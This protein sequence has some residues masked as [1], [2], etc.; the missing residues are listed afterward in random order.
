MLPKKFKYD[1]CIIGGAGHIGFPLGLAFA[2][3]KKKVL[4][5]DKNTK[6]LDLIKKKKVPFLE[7]GAENLLKKYYKYLVCSSNDNCITQ[8][9]VIIVCIGTPISKKLIPEKKKFLQ[10]FN[11]IK[12]LISNNQLLIIRSSVYPGVCDEVK[13]ILGN[14]D[15][16][17]YCPERIVQGLSLIELPRLTQLVSGFNNFSIQK[18]T[19]LFKL[20]CKN[21]IIV[22]IIEAELIKLFSNAYRYINF[23]ISNQFYMMCENVG[24]NFNSV[25]GKMMKGYNRNSDIPKPGFTAGPCLLKDTMQLSDFFKHKFP[26]GKAA[27]NINESLPIFLIKNFEKKNKIKNKTVGVLGLAFKAETDDT[28]DS[29]SLKLIDYLKKKKIK[30]LVSDEYVKSSNL[31]SVDELLK[32]SD[33]IIICTPHNAYKKITFPNKPII[34]VWNIKN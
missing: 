23:S 22:K 4:L 26:L 21:T 25:R 19:K 16:I 10:Y 33:I 11:S 28:R 30:H 27:M 3:K 29:L 14:F 1:I 9:K 24:L 18:S 12:N 34:D 31:V 6:C 32:K 20:I 13:K 5:L 7:K 2:S 15:N 8:C 17:A